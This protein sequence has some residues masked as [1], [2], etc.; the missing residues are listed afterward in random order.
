MMKIKLTDIKDRTDWA[1]LDQNPDFANQLVAIL[2]QVDGFSSNGL[3]FYAD[4]D[5]WT[6]DYWNSAN[7]EIDQD[8]FVIVNDQF[9]IRS[10]NRD[11][12]LNVHYYQK[13]TDLA[14]KDLI[15]WRWWSYFPQDQVL[16]LDHRYKNV[17]YLNIKL[18]KPIDQ[19]DQKQINAIGKLMTNAYDLIVKDDRLDWEQFDKQWKQGFDKF[20]DVGIVFDLNDFANPKILMRWWN[21]GTNQYENDY[22]KQVLKADAPLLTYLNQFKQNGYNQLIINLINQVDQSEQV[23]EKDK[24]IGINPI[25]NDVEQLNQPL[26]PNFDIYIGAKGKTT[27]GALNNLVKNIKAIIQYDDSIKQWFLS[28]LKIIYQ[29][30]QAIYIISGALNIV[31]N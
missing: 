16:Q 11:D 22:L 15:E 14:N 7:Y 12:L 29:E 19:Y 28:D 8:T 5:H 10:T 23:S 3:K 30:E 17:P 25:N 13:L 6:Y 27:I 20:G 31:I 9:V 24:Q 26:V 18:I 2:N 21:N 4:G 1:Y